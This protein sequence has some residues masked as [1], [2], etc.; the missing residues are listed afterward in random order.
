[1]LQLKQISQLLA[2]VLTKDSALQGPVAVSLLS[3]KG[4][5]LT[6]VTISGLGALSP[7]NLRI[8]SLLAI[9][10]FH[11]QPAADDED[12]DS[13]AVVDLDGT[14][15]AMVKQF[16]T[17]DGDSNDMFVVLFYTELA[18]ALAKVK[19]DGVTEALAR[20]LEGYKAS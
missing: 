12:L 20:K 2:Q 11:Q 9:N 15:R 18:D 16:L 6:T 17:I 3:N 7:D 19:L 10:S 1:M 5:P 13:W 8:Y 14:F 4:L